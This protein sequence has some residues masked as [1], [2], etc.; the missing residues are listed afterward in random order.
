[1]L[2]LYLNGDD[3]DCHYIDARPVYVRSHWMVKNRKRVHVHHAAPR[4]FKRRLATAVTA[5]NSPK[6]RRQPR[7]LWKTSSNSAKPRL[8]TNWSTSMRIEKEAPKSS[9]FHHFILSEAQPSSA[10]TGM[11]TST[12]RMICGTKERSSFRA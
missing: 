11:K 10:P 7:V 4:L 5:A 12:F 8:V 3:Q 1:M 2:F 9:A 6:P